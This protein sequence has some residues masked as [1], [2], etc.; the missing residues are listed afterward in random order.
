MATNATAISTYKTYLMYK[1]TDSDEYTK[2]LD[3]SSYPDLGGD[4]ENIDVTTLSD[5]M[6]KFIGGIQDTDSLNFDAFYNAADF[7]KV[8]ALEGKQVDMAVWFGASAA[9]VPDGSEGKFS[10]RGE[11]YAYITGGGVN[12]AVGMRV[13]CVPNTVITFSET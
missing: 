11:V 2:L 1:A 9:G 12:E 5:G 6:R 10:F 4:P 3:I 13:T 8:Q 7:K